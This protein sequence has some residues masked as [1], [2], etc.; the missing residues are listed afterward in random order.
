M[1]IEMSV[2]AI[3]IPWIEYNTWNPK[4]LDILPNGPTSLNINNIA[5]PMIG[6]G[7]D[8]GKSKAP[9]IIF[10]PKKLTLLKKYA[11]GKASKIETK[12]DKN[13]VIIVKAI[14]SR[15]KELKLSDKL[16]NW[17]KVEL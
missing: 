2:W 13:E 17:P 16:E 3:I 10:F 8:D 6:C 11:L 14:D 5:I 4:R 1:G 9:S 7:I 15:T 12:E